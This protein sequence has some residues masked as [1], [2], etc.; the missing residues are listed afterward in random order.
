M[1]GGVLV[2][3]AVVTVVPTTTT[4]CLIFCMSAMTRNLPGPK[5]KSNDYDYYN[6]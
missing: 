3:V 2:V 4:V 6:C 1:G 5:V